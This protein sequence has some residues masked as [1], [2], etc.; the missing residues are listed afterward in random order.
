MTDRSQIPH[1]G[2]FSH[3]RPPQAHGKF[4][5]W[6]R[7][8]I[9]RLQQSNDQVPQQH[10]ECLFPYAAA[11]TGIILPHGVPDVDVNGNSNIGW[12]AACFEIFPANLDP[13]PAVLTT[14]KD[15]MVYLSDLT[16]QIDTHVSQD[17]GPVWLPPRAG[18]RMVLIEVDTD[19]SAFTVDPAA[20]PS[21]ADFF[22]EYPSATGIAGAPAPI[23]SWAAT[24]YSRGQ[25]GDKRLFESRF[26]PS[27]DRGLQTLVGIERV[28]EDDVGT[29]P[30]AELFNLRHGRSTSTVASAPDGAKS[31]PVH[32]TDPS[33]WHFRVLSDVKLWAKKSVV[34]DVPN[35][36]I[37]VPAT[38]GPPASSAYTTFATNHI[39]TVHTQGISEE[40]RI[41]IGR[42]YTKKLIT[43]VTD[44]SSIINTE[45]FCPN[46]LFLYL[47]PNFSPAANLLLVNNGAAPQR[48]YRFP[49][50][51]TL[52]S[53]PTYYEQLSIPSGAGTRPVINPTHR[54]DRLLCRHSYYYD[55][56]QGNDPELIGADRDAL[57]DSE[58]QGEQAM[59]Q[60]QLDAGGPRGAAPSQPFSDQGKRM[61]YTQQPITHYFTMGK[62]KRTYYGLY[63]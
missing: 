44:D 22:Q 25:W 27:F 1:P 14:A 7:Q 6:A 5:K 4:Q 39:P 43:P 19:K 36:P 21:V 10:T 34:Q 50:A 41:M 61:K 58:I 12:D 60:H 20:I 29:N 51:G 3:K 13:Y 46:R 47:I 42:W 26:R 56:Q 8:A 11:A 40:V 38:P 33:R 18:L 23:S 15:D 45:Y 30:A 52:P 63:D 53:G 59:Y 2:V 16:F 32:E 28:A 49:G 48:R 37:V 55:T 31:F 24:P 62:R 54:L 17:T 35:Y 9:R 57:M